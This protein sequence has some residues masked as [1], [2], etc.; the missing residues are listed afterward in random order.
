MEVPVCSRAG[1][2]IEVLL[3]VEQQRIR[4]TYFGGR[5]VCDDHLQR[6]QN[7]H[8][9]VEGGGGRC[10]VWYVCEV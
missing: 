4:A 2:E 1:E 8:G 5:D 7:S 3:C 9:T 10:D 6:V